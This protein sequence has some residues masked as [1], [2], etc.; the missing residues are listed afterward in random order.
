MFVDAGRRAA[1]DNVDTARHAEVN[2]RCAV[3]RVEKQV[4]GATPDRFDCCTRKPLADFAC[5]RSSQAAFA[6]IHTID[7]LTLKV[8]SNATAAGL[9]FRKFGHWQSLLQKQ[10]SPHAAGF[11]ECV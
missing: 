1:F 7:A 3:P 2:D 5:Y 11:F 10:K 9:D 4:L 6:N 8:G